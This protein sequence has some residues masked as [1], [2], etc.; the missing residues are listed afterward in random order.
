M[1]LPSFVRAAQGDNPVVAMQH[2][3]LLDLLSGVR[4]AQHG[5]IIVPSHVRVGSVPREPIF[6]GSLTLVE[7]M[8][9]GC[10][11]RARKDDIWR[12]CRQLGLPEYALTPALRRRN[13]PHGCPCAT[14]DLHRMHAPRVLPMISPACMPMCH[15]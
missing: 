12:L 3:M 11:A 15:S 8:T 13:L 9:Y 10:G 4:T 6:M 14:C 7:N 1:S 2:S 5:A